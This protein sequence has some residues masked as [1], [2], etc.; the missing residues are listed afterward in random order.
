MCKHTQIRIPIVFN[1]WIRA[2]DRDKGCFVCG[3]QFPVGQIG[4]D[5][6]AGHVRSRGS[7]DH[8]RYNEDNVHGECKSCNSSWGAKPHEIK[9]GAIRRIGQD[10]YDALEANNT[11]TKWRREWLIDSI[12]IYKERLKNLKKDKK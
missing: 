6:D 4:G 8:L 1:A 3:V 10:R 9:A 11:P 12:A 2:R 7:A 5:F